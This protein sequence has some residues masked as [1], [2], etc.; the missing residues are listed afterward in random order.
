MGLHKPRQQPIAAQIDLLGTGQRLLAVGQVAFGGNG[1]SA[2]HRYSQGL[3][4]SRVQREDGPGQ[5]DAGVVQ[6]HGCV[7]VLM[8]AVTF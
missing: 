2:T 4:L 6:G 1:A 7:L 5:Q 3:R 8:V